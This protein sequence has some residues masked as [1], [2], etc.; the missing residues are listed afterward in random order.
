[1]RTDP[2]LR[3]SDFSYGFWVIYRY[4]HIRIIDEAVIRLPLFRAKPSK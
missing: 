1:M 4:E 3:K 2:D